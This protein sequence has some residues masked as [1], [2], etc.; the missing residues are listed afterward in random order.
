YPGPWEAS[1]ADRPGDF[2]NIDDGQKT[3]N[4]AGHERNLARHFLQ[5]FAN[6]FIHKIST[7][8]RRNPAERSLPAKPW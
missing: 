3:A 7:A 6:S 5:H 1:R 2:R 4:P 8:V